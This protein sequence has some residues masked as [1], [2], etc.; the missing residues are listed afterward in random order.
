MFSGIGKSFTFLLLFGWLAICSPVAFAQDKTLPPSIAVE[1]RSLLSPFEPETKFNL[2]TAENPVNE[3]TRSP[4]FFRANRSGESNI[5]QTDVEISGS[6]NERSSAD[7]KPKINDFARRFPDNEVRE[8]RFEFEA[9]LSVEKKSFPLRSSSANAAR[10]DDPK[11]A[12][13]SDDAVNGKD[14]G[15]RWRAA[16]G[17][18]LMF[19]AIQHGYAFTQP[20]TREAM[21]GKFWKEYVESVKSLGGWA[22]GGR[23]F[24][25]YIA[26]PMQG[27][28]TGFIYV[29]NDPK[30]IKQKFGA[31]G[32][33]WRSRLKAMA[34]SAVWST[35][36]EIGPISQASIGN[37]G[38]KGKQTYI[39]IVV[40]PTVGTA[41]L[42]SEDAIDRFVMQRIER[43]SDNFYL[44]IFS[45]M[46]LS[47]TR[48]FANLLRF[49]PP[50]HRDRPPAR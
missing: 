1:P 47:P 8:R 16:T 6:E 18:T 44:R 5:Y 29:Q 49:K 43:A 15:F 32:D 33:Y 17:Q 35:Q 41:L 36:F 2:P 50:W 14:Q 12:A 28:M 26:H 40:T 30:A 22:D 10:L 11:N 39:D 27:S 4:N 37:V 23:F 25:N 31:S 42:V 24:T 19:L 20:K 38:L 13:A 9:S 7:D 21:K 48:V 34:W 46:L 3:T 45:R